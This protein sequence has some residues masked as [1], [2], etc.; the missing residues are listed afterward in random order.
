M[1]TEPLSAV[2]WS[3]WLGGMVLLLFALLL[4]Q[5]LGGRL[6]TGDGGHSPVSVIWSVRRWWFLAR[7]AYYARTARLLRLEARLLRCGFVFR[8]RLVQFVRIC[9]FFRVIHNRKCVDGVMPPNESSSATAQKG[10][11]KC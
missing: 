6:P 10:G 9:L 3:A 1:L 2:R 8:R 7:S 4:T 11:G 5:L